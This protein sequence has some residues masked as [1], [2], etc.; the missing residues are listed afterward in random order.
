LYIKRT[1]PELERERVKERGR[2]SIDEVGFHMGSS[3]YFISTH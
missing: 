3:K 1:L 2:E